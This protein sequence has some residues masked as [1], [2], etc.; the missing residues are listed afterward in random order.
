MSRLSVFALAATLVSGCGFTFGSGPQVEPSK[1]IQNIKV[2]TGNPYEA[3]FLQRGARL[4]LDR[5]Y[6][7][8][9]VPAALEGAAFIRSANNDKVVRTNE[10]MTFTVTKDA[11]VYVAY[12][13]RGSALPEWLKGWEPTSAIMTTSDVERRMLRKFY[14]AKSIVKVGGN[15][16]GPAAGSE[17]NY[18]VIVAPKS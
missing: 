6:V 8:T 2:S 11:Y 16:A 17:S 4:Y 14:K 3:D 13:Q 15:W 10:Y 9:G 5:K 12:D 1:L 7:V 18:N